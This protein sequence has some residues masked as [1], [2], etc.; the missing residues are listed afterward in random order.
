MKGCGPMA[1]RMEQ[2]NNKYPENMKHEVRTAQFMSKPLSGGAE[3]QLRQMG[4]STAGINQISS[5]QSLTGKKDLQ[6]IAILIALM[7][8]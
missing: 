7:L 5:Q 1:I 8:G 3:N 4:M 6:I 2:L